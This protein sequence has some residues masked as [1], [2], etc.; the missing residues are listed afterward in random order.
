MNLNRSF[1]AALLAFTATATQAS[2]V[3][4]TQNFENPNLSAFNAGLGPDASFSSV[5]S[6]YPNQPAGFTFAQTN[7]VETLRVGGNQAWNGAGF[8]DPQNKAGNYVVS[9]LSDAQ[10]DLL[11]LSFNV[12]SYQ[13]FN[14]QLDISSIDL[15][16][17]GGQFVPQG[18]LA[19]SFRLS[20]YDNP[21]GTPNVGTS[22]LLDSVDIT[23]LLSSAP[24][25]FNW[26]NHIVGLD[27]TGNTN[28]NVTVVIDELVGG[29]AALDN[30]R[31]VASDTQGDVGQVPEPASLALLGLGLAAL[32]FSLRRPV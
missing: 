23:G 30:F 13:F 7:T 25:V 31:I 4:Y 15:N 2:V 22:T 3:L 17:W 19:P 26:T 6:I 27:A 1:L 12:G 21:S 10:N 5:N 8:Q 11:G 18:G 29:Y 24:Y 32:G 14:F 9:M 16:F 28:G 20:L